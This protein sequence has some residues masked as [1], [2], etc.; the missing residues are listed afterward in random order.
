MFGPPRSRRGR[1]N[2]A[3]RSSI[4]LACVALPAAAQASPVAARH[5]EL[6][7]RPGR[8]HRD[9]HGAVGAQRRPRRLARHGTRR[10]RAARRRER[11]HARHRRGGRA[12]PARPHDGVQ[13]RS[14]PAGLARERPHGHRPRQPHA[15]G[16]RVSLHLVGPA[17]RSADAGRRG[18]S[19]G[20][21]RLRDRLG[22]DDRLGQLGRAAQRREPLQRLLAGRQLR[23]ARH[24]DGVPGQPDGALEHLAQQRRHGH[25]PRC[26]PATARSR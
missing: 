18:R 23:D 14:R 2:A 26:S 9:E 25:R 12:G 22:A 21:V 13:R 4:G 6:V 8:L 7:R 3:P 17:H 11:R 5:D 20:A 1:R 10:L 15:Q 19:G 24:H 16:R